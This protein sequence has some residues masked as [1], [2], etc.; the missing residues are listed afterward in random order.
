MFPVEPLAFENR[1][2]YDLLENLQRM[3]RIIKRTKQIII[4]K[5]QNNRR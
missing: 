1:F 3:K 2:K 4:K 5:E